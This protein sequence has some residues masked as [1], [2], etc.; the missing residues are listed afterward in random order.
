MLSGWCKEK[1]QF[2]RLVVTGDSVMM[3]PRGSV[4]RS[5]LGFD[6]RNEGI[7]AVRT[8]AGERGKG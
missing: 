2:P 3:P 4:E 7:A 8:S 1:L 5:Q 6:R